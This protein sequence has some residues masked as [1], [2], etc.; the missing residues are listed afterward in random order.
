VT[1]ITFILLLGV[2]FTETT[3]QMLYRMA[4]KYPSRFFVYV[5]PA[6]ALYVIGAFLIYGILKR[7]PVGVGRP[8]MGINYAAI[9]VAAWLF[10]G[11]TVG[12]RRWLGVALILVGFTIIAV[13]QA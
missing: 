7:L 11:E 8:L 1:L 6:A 5:A 10:F 3:Q 13:Y 2:V 12:P 4:G 9:A